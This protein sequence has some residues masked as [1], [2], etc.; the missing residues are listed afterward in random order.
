MAN[1]KKYISLSRLS[2]FLD[3]LRNTFAPQSHKHTVADLTDYTVDSALSSTSNN[4]VANSAID[5]EFEAVSQAMNSL[6]LAIDGKADASHDHDDTYYTETEID[7]K[8]STVNTSITNITNGEIVVKEAEHA[9]SADEATH[10]T[11]ADSA[12]NANHATSADSATN[13]NHAVSAD[14]ATTAESC[15]GNAATATKAA[16]DASGNVIIDTY[17]TK[18]DAS[19]KLTEAKNYADSAANTVKND[20]LNGAGTAYDT[21]KELGD[22]IDENQDAIE[23]LEI[24]AAG[25]ADKVHTHAI[26]DVNDLQ[27]ALD[28]KADASHSHNSV[29]IREW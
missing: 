3:N 2:I 15:T 14:S 13:A 11:S 27:A 23:A 29:I 6:D 9:N 26:A 22:L 21:L 5:A 20:L 10:A 12:T 7:Q 8:L 24:V 16:Q 19:A 25:K 18:S 17:E 1:N 4:P 28:N